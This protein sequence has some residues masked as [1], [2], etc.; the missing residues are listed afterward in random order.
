MKVNITKDIACTH[1]PEKAKSVISRYE[2]SKYSIFR[3]RYKRSGMIGQYK[4]VVCTIPES[5]EMINSA[6]SHEYISKLVETGNKN[7]L[8]SLK[9]GGQ[10]YFVDNIT[11]RI[12]SDVDTILANCIFMYMIMIGYHESRDFGY[13]CLGLYPKKNTISEW[14]TNLCDIE[15]N[16]GVYQYVDLV[17]DMFICSALEKCEDTLDTGAVFSNAIDL[18]MDDVC[19]RINRMFPDFAIAT[20]H[21]TSTCS[22]LAKIAITRNMLTIK[23]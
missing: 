13:Q 17:S 7:K 6:V 15:A 11:D 2:K 18:F 5:R 4:P 14:Y 8:N 9:R 22:S 1:I 3:E 19:V 23:I 12:L 21:L 16:E 20:E 10:I